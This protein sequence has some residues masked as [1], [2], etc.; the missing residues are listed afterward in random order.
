VAASCV[1]EKM[2]NASWVWH[3]CADNIFIDRERKRGEIRL[4]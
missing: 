2:E 4:I 1:K 3:A